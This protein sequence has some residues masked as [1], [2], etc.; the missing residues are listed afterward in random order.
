MSRLMH[1]PEPIHHVIS[2]P[3]HP[4][5]PC[6]LMSHLHPVAPPRVHLGHGSY[7]H[8]IDPPPKQHYYSSHVVVPSL[9]VH[10]YQYVYPHHAYTHPISHVPHHNLKYDE[11][12]HHT[13]ASSYR[14]SQFPSYHEL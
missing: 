8:L 1:D 10:I 13:Q 4:T 6:I 14:P 5:I 7:S 12:S 3:I 2:H 9:K 11:S